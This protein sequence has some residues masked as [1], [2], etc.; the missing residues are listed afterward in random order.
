MNPNDVFG[1]ALEKGQNA[2]QQIGKIASD[3]TVS[4]AKTATNQISGNSDGQDLPTEANTPVQDNQLVASEK[5]ETK[6]MIKDIYAQS[7]PSEAVK[8]VEQTQAE[9]KAKIAKL[10][11]QLHSEVYYE[12]LV[13]PQKP[14]EER[15]AEK[16][17][18]EKM[19]DL[20]DAQK[21]QEKQKPIAVSN[22]Q[23]AAETRNM[24]GSG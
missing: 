7:N 12:P 10:R 9:D 6:E 5:L 2:V 1:E 19:E 14:Q 8:P 17:E 16:V 24:G 23:T 18:R 15:P 13:N 4:A 20:Q 11:Q 21:K 3:S 22:A